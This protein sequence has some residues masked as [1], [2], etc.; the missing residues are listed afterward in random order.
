MTTAI[1]APEI[2]GAMIARE[3][4]RRGPRRPHRRPPPSPGGDQA[5]FRVSFTIR[6]S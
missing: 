6:V 2:D 3:A 4:R 1:A 5:D